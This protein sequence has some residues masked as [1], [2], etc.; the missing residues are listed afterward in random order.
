MFMIFYMRRA[1][2][3]CFSTLPSR[4]FHCPPL[5]PKD[6]NTTIS[7]R[8]QHPKHPLAPTAHIPPSCPKYSQLT[9][10][11]CVTQWHLKFYSTSSASS[12]HQSTNRSRNR[13]RSRNH[14][15]Y[16]HNNNTINNPSNEARRDHHDGRRAS[17]QQPGST[18]PPAVQLD[19]PCQKPP[20]NLQDL[21]A[22]ALWF[23]AKIQCREPLAGTPSRWI[24]RHF[25]H[26]SGLS[27]VL[28]AHIKCKVWSP[29]SPFRFIF[30]NGTNIPPWH[31]L[32]MQA[33]IDAASI[34][35]AFRVCTRVGHDLQLVLRKTRSSNNSHFMGL[36]SFFFVHSL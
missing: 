8:F 15:H 4:Y 10:N 19:R 31:E 9:S 13:N 22:M 17:G 12:S 14:S 33:L 6:R 1:P 3:A 21:I 27:C 34:A 16:H 30:P 7:R 28:L 35:S 36:H 20:F 25:G 24:E 5:Y 32:G 2:A 11:T 18:P 26:W 23:L 29:F